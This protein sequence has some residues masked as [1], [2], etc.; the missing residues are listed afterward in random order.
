MNRLRFLLLL[1]VLL[2]PLSSPAEQ[3]RRLVADPWPPFNDK[4]LLNNGVA[5]DLEDELVARHHLSCSLAGVR[6]Q[7][8]FLPQPLSE[9]ELNILISLRH[10]G[11][12]KSLTTSIERLPPFVP[13]AAMRRSCGTTA[14]NYCQ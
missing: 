10:P 2:H 3:A 12:S 14:F 1:W 6:D 13:M 9:N 11:T 8:E 7:L 5:S 4:S